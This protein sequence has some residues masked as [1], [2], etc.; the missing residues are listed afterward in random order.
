MPASGFGSVAPSSPASRPSPA[1]GLRPALAPAA[2][3]ARVGSRREQGPGVE[4]QQ[5][6]GECGGFGGLF[7]W[8]IKYRNFLNWLR[9]TACYRTHFLHIRLSAVDA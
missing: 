4:D 1:G 2:G 6:R 7:A 5:I 8:A 3:G 9:K